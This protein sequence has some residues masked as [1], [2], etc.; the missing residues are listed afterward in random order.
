MRGGLLAL[1]CASL[2]VAS[3]LSDRLSDEETRLESSMWIKR[4]PPRKGFSL[5]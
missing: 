3:L 4:S 1:W 5:P 2:S